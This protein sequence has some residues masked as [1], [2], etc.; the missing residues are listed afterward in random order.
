[1]APTAPRTPQLFGAHLGIRL[2]QGNHLRHTAE[3]MCSMLELVSRRVEQVAVLPLGARVEVDAW[4]DR[5]WLP[6]SEA[7]HLLAGRERTPVEVSPRV[8]DLPSS[9][10]A[11]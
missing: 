10:R 3:L 9:G 7:V 8:P 5:V 2:A 1:M 11:R 4:R 6:G